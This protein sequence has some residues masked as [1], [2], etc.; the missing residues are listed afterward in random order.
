MDGT[1][2]ACLPLRS[3]VDLGPG[4]LGACARSVCRQCLTDSQRVVQV[5]NGRSLVGGRHV[6]FLG[7][8]KARNGLDLACRRW[9]QGQECQVYLRIGDAAKGRGMV[10]CL[11]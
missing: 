9:D 7:E 10:V 11:A 4:R 1:R 3:A 5:D 8:W 2:L 6:F